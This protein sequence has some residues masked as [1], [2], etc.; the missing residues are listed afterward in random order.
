MQQRLATYFGGLDPQQ[1]LSVNGLIDY[2]YVLSLIR[3]TP[4]VLRI[5]GTL[6]INGGTVDIQLPVTPGAFEN[7][8]WTQTV[9]TAL[10][11]SGQ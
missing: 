9:G 5:T 6:T 8:Y 10:P 2:D 7:A 3:T 11:F 4:G 1:A